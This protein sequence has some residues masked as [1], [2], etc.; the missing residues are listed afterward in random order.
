[1]DRYSPY[2]PNLLQQR[3]QLRCN[4]SVIH[5]IVAVDKDNGAFAQRVGHS[6]VFGVSTTKRR[7]GILFP[8]NTP[9]NYNS[10][11]LTPPQS[12]KHLPSLL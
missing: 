7:N 3:F 6:L 12:Q 1:M 5:P 10:N 2:H 9:Y 4:N 8:T 11:K